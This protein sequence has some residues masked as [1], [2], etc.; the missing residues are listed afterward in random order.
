MT[1][2]SPISEVLWGGFHGEE[3]LPVNVFWACPVAGL[4]HSA[5]CQTACWETHPTGGYPMT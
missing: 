4:Y 2:I 3:I 5:S 1:A